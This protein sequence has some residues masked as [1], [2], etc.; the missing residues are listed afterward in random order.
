MILNWDNSLSVGNDN[1]DNQH[2]ELF[3]RLNKLLE[4][5][6]EGQGKSEVINTLDFLEVYVIKHFNYEEE[7]QKKNKYPKFNVQHKQHEEFKN[8]LKE[9]R[10]VFETTGI[11]SLFVINTQQKMVKWCKDHI[12]NSDME[13]GEYLTKNTKESILKSFL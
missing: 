6:K 13:L 1:I 9:L 8:E 3:Y 2:K 5:M 10:R 11:S 4:A 12:M 7:I